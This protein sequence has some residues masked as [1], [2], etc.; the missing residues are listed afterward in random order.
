M[1]KAYK[2]LSSYNFFSI[3]AAFF[4]TE[5]IVMYPEG[6]MLP[7]TYDFRGRPWYWEALESE[8]KNDE[9]VLSDPYLSQPSEQMV[10]TLSRSVKGKL[11]ST[12]DYVAGLEI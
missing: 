3:Y 11:S 4:D 6:T 2:S 8:T 10:I 1:N 9:V 12:F 5:I 7:D